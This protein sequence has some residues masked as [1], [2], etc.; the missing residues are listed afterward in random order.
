MFW[1]GLPQLLLLQWN[2]KCFHTIYYHYIRTNK[3]M[4][5]STNIRSL[6]FNKM[7]SNPRYMDYDGNTTITNLN[8]FDFNTQFL[9]P[10]K[11]TEDFPLF[12]VI[13]N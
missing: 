1:N 13:Y 11:D 3:A 12:T 10:L 2:Y 7:Q 9:L 5:I 4:L 8:Y 6:I